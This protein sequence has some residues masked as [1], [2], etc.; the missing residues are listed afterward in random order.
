MLKLGQNYDL[1]CNMIIR[2]PRF[3]YD[4]SD[5]GPRYFSAGGKPAQRTDFELRNERGMIIQCS[6]FEPL[7]NWDQPMPCVIYLHGNGGC[8]IEALDVVH[9]LLP[10]E[11]SVVALDF[12]GSGLSEGE[13]VSLGYWEQFDVATVVQYLREANRCSTIGLWGRSMGAVTAILYSIQDPSIASMILDSPFCSL[14]KIAEDLVLNIETLQ[15][16]PRFTKFAV[17]LAMKP[18]R[19]TIKKKAKFD[20]KALEIL[21]LIGK[22]YIP[23]LFI[24]GQDDNF[25][26]PMHSELLYNLYNGDKNR[27]LVEGNHNSMRPNFVMDSAVIFFNNTLNNGAVHTTTK[28]STLPELP[29]SMPQHQAAIQLQQFN[30]IMHPLHSNGTPSTQVVQATPAALEH[31]GHGPT[32]VHAQGLAHESQGVVME[33][34]DVSA[35]PL[36]NHLAQH[37]PHSPQNNIHN[38]TTMARGLNGSVIID[39]MVIGNTVIIDG[40]EVILDSEDQDAYYSDSHSHPDSSLSTTP[41]TNNILS[42]TPPTTVS[43]TETTST[44]LDENSNNHYVNGVTANH[45]TTVTNHVLNEN[46]SPPTNPT[47]PTD[48]IN[49]A[50]PTNPTNLTTVPPTHE[51]IAPPSPHPHPAQ[52]YIIHDNVN[53]EE[54]NDEE[55]PE[56]IDAQSENTTTPT[57]SF[58][59]EADF[60]E[61]LDN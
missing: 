21:E 26:L 41:T 51:P 8:R 59:A 61:D 13:Y 16:M 30:N 12:A 39:D 43:H 48:P 24:H 3:V 54:E 6:H 32:Q 33:E 55:I 56:E 22:C 60:P 19:N 52:G 7:T 45:T 57:L 17:G 42:S 27:I 10:A 53:N 58:R 38:H 25:V 2:P 50:N 4:I 40:K 14:Q 35:D 18:I 5:L 9:T 47:I 11:V 36:M 44:K 28:A 15:K 49:P 37:S 46:V 31:A 1:L 20:I 29:L 23:A 34:I